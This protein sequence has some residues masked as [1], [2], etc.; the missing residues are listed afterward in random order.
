MIEHHPW[1]IYNEAGSGTHLLSGGQMR[2]YLSVT[3][4]MS[5]LE[6]GFLLAP[7][8]PSPSRPILFYAA[9]NIIQ[10]AD[11]VQIAQ[12]YQQTIHPSFPTTISAGSP[13]VT[14]GTTDKQAYLSGVQSLTGRLCKHEM[15]K[16]VVSRITV[17]PPLQA[18]H[19]LRVFLAL[20]TAY[21]L[22]FV[23]LGYFPGQGIWMG[24]SPEQLIRCQGRSCETMAL[25]GTRLRGT[26]EDWGAKEIEEQGI[27]SRYIRD[28]LL[29]QSMQDITQTEP[30][31]RTAGHLEHLCT[32]FSFQLP[33]MTT[34]GPLIQA[35]HPTP[36][37]CGLPLESAL[38][39][40]QANEK[41]ERAYYSG[42]L[43]PCHANGNIS[44]YVNL[45]CMQMTNHGTMLYSGGGI[46]CQ[47]DPLHEWE[48][49]EHKAQTLLSVIEKVRF[50]SG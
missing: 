13:S 16:V 8:V 36:A 11:D 4:A 32:G 41:H 19:L 12:F 33:E 28:I 47:S 50:L 14:S 23:Y 34:P 10:N 7:F 15:E 27:V 49:T 17:I 46:T 37:I 42:F 22:A 3:D 25:A 48:E 26:S 35:L 45:R 39:W 20:K 24:A 2:S 31:T 44:L 40:I 18:D 1:V 38:S 30:H 5:T 29:L 9:D 21:P 6:N 43:G